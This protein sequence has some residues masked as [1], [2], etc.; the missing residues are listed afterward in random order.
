MTRKKP[1]GRTELAKRNG[2]RFRVKATIERFGTKRG[3]KGRE[4]QTVLFRNV[5]D[6]AGAPLADHL[7]I[8]AGK[9]SSGLKPGDAISFDARVDEYE[10]GY[11]GRR[12]D[13]Y[14]EA[15][16][17]WHLERPTKVERL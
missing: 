12:D 2:K 6:E 1:Q 7:W 8:T 4:L 11:F 13:V 15:S 3:W 14:V 9:W 16:R 10:K 5:I 17:D